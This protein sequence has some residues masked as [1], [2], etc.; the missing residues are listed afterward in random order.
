MNTTKA[1]HLLY[2]A[3]VGPGWLQITAWHGMSGGSPVW[4][5]KFNRSWGSKFSKSPVIFT[6]EWEPGLSIWG[7]QRFNPRGR[8]R[9]IP[10]AVLADVEAW[11]RGRP[12]GKVEIPKSADTLAVLAAIKDCPTLEAVAQAFRAL[13]LLKSPEPLALDRLFRIADELDP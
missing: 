6:S 1:F 7:D 13:A 5:V 2:N 10:V 11:L 3:P 12:V 9:Q 4:L 8:S